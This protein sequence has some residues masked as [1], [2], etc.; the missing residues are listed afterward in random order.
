[1]NLKRTIRD[2]AINTGLSGKY[3][4]YHPASGLIILILDYIFFTG[5]VFLVTAPVSIGLLF[6]FTFLLLIFIQRKY[7]RD[8]WFKALLKA[9]AGAI[10]TS[11]PT[12]IFGTIM[13]SLI[14]AVSGLNNTKKLNSDTPKNT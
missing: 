10:V 8:S 1:M 9:V 5:E 2:K 3:Q 12:P 6:F 14:L 7:G 4:I 13:G 11:I